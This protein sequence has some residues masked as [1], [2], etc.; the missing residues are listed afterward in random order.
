VYGELEKVQNETFMPYF[1]L[2]F[3]NFPAR[4]EDDHGADGQ[5]LNP[6]NFD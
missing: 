1:V 6:V 4:T 5:G 3:W 2:I